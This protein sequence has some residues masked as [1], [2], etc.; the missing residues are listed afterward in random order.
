MASA[1]ARRPDGAP[2]VRSDPTAS[3]IQVGGQASTSMSERIR[4]AYNT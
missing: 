1:H 2:K 3:A 4:V